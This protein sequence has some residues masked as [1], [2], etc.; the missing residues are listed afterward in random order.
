M[1]GRSLILCL[2]GAL[3]ASLVLAA[4]CQASLTE[5]TTTVTFNLVGGTNPMATDVEVLY[6]PVA[7]GFSGLTVT[8]TGG[9][10]GTVTPSFNSGM[11]EVDVSF[12]ASSKTTGTGLVF[13]FLTDSSN[14]PIGLKNNFLS[15]VTGN[16][17]NQNLVV[18]ISTSGVVPEPSTFAVFGIGLVGFFAV[19]RFAKRA[20]AA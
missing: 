20:K 12:G 10:N 14:N 16:P 7:T 15:G 8:N 5:V 19:R 6:S 13:T 11:N 2:S 17:T 1:K 18:S 3:L 9:L 4:P